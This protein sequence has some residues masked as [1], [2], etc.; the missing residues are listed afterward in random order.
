MTSF[1]KL[2]KQSTRFFNIV[3]Y[4]VPELLCIHIHNTLIIQI[5]Y[6]LQVNLKCLETAQA[7]FI[8]FLFLADSFGS[9]LD[10]TIKISNRYNEKGSI[11]V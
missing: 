10:F 4:F 3:Q 5:K 1:H 6:R 11:F 9:L 8:L 2:N 7:Y